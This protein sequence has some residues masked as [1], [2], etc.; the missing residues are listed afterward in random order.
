MLTMLFTHVRE[1]THYY[2]KRKQIRIAKKIYIYRDCRIHTYLDKYVNYILSSPAT[3]IKCKRS[4]KHVF[5]TSYRHI[6]VLY[7]KYVI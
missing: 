1:V 4:Q 5:V 3:A 6:Y 7:L 2:Q